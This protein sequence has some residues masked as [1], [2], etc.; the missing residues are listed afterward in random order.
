[1]A[2]FERFLTVFGAFLLFLQG[3]GTFFGAWRAVPGAGRPPELIKNGN[4]KKCPFL[5]FGGAV[6]H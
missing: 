5:L 6:N 4:Y 2:V 3:F 1:M